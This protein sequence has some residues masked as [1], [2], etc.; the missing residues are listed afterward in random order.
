M[1]NSTRRLYVYVANRVEKIKKLS[2]P[3][4][5]NYVPTDTNPSDSATRSLN[6]VEFQTSAWLTN[7]ELMIPDE[8][9]EIRTATT[10]VELT[11]G[12]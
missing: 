9:S 6:A 10:M 12:T 8:D 2:D 3:E 4:Q 1:S 7:Q 5:W 11:K